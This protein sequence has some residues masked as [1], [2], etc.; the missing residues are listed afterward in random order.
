MRDTY[1]NESMF[2]VKWPL[3]TEE[4]LGKQGN[5]RW[6]ISFKGLID[7]SRCKGKGEEKR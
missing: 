4:G 2:K 5:T 7:F 6:H 3:S 1:T